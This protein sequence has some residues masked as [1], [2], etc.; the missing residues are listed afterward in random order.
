MHGFP[1]HLLL[2]L[3]VLQGKDDV[4][5]HGHV[6]IEGIVL[7]DQAHAPL[8][9][10][11]PGHVLIAEENPSL[12]RNLQAADQVQRRALSASAGAQQAHQLPVRNLKVEV[13]DRG[14]V[15]SLFRPGSKSLGQMFQHYFHG[16][17]S[18][19][20]SRSSFSIRSSEKSGV[21]AVI[22]SSLS[23]SSISM[24][25]SSA[26]SRGFPFLPVSR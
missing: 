14:Y 10:R 18:P 5:L 3:Q 11:N 15:L 25:V 17:S 4:L 8:L 6:R 13:A 1:G 19:S 7:E 21:Q 16:V 26:G 20:V 22:H 23:S 24:T 9:R 12:R 2:S